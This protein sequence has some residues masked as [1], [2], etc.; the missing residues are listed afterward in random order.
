MLITQTFDID[1]PVD[2][3]WKFFDDIPLVASCIPGA[4]LREHVGDDEYRGDVTISAGPVKLEFTGAVKITSRDD[5]RKAIVLDAAGADK[6][7]RGAANALLNVTLQPLGGST[8]VNMSM[9]LAISG[10]AAQY[11]RG[12][13]QDFTAVLIDQ[14]AGSMKLRMNAI[15]EGRDPMDVG[16]P[17]AASGLAIGFTA[18]TK[19]AKRI[20]ARFFLPYTPAPSR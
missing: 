13:V 11:G 1:Q 15:A 19:A 4:D 3:V 5:A 17:K 2:Q 14:T 16:A 10:A 20:F 18:F 8:R 12:L 7:G 6:K 9:E